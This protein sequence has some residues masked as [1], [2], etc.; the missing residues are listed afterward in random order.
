MKGQQQQKQERDRRQ[1]R[2]QVAAVA[3][4][5]AV[6]LGTAMPTARAWDHEDGHQTPMEV[7]ADITDLF[8]WMS[9][10]GARVNLVL[11]VTQAAAMNATF[12]TNVQ[13]V[14]HTA[15]R[16]K[17]G[18]PEGKNPTTIICTFAANQAVSCWVGPGKDYVTGDA[19][20]SPGITSESGRIQVFT[21]VRNDPF[22]MNRQGWDVF[23]D[24]VH[25]GN[26]TPYV[27]DAAGCPLISEDRVLRLR[28]E[29]K[30]SDERG[31]GAFDFY[32][33]L[34]VQSIVLS[35]DKRLLTADGP[36]LSVWASTNRGN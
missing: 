5:A 28:N 33:S 35:V 18:G 16:S 1:R 17:A 6:A 26:R 12:P 7:G 10:D 13:Y 36:I 32:A 24:T 34:N 8:A 11:D 20:N 29:L 31:S 25:R 14:F 22:F 15:S 19:R 4:V 23:A 9:P 3:A 2:G 27:W 30:T 21:G